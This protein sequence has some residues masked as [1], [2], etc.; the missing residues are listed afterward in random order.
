MKI[1]GKITLL[2]PLTNS[3]IDEML[4]SGELIGL[5]VERAY[6]VTGVPEILSLV[7]PAQVSED[8][9]TGFKQVIAESSWIH[10]QEA[11][12]FVAKYDNGLIDLTSSYVRSDID[13]DLS[14]PM[15]SGKSFKISFIVPD[16]EEGQKVVSGI[17][18]YG[19]SF[20]SEL[21][22]DLSE[23]GIEIDESSTTEQITILNT[24]ISGFKVNFEKP[25]GEVGA[26]IFD[27]D[28]KNKILKI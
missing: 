8:F 2:E 4:E 3:K 21:M 17:L 9:I 10:E 12:I 15:V 7:L 25:V 5:I 24:C 27:Y 20:P 1:I 13:T 16:F 26:Y 6:S 28:F 11:F 19:N 23:I 18:S 22:E 14:R